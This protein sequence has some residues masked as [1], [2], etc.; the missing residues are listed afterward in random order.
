M[1]VARL[2]ETRPVNRAEQNVVNLVRASGG[3]VQ[4]RH[5]EASGLRRADIQAAARSGLLLRV[6][7]GWYAVPDAPPEVRR[8]ATMGGAATSASVARLHGL[9][10]HDDRTLHVRVPRNASRLVSPDRRD[11]D[12]P[13]RLDPATERVCVHYRSEPAPVSARDPL[14]LALAEMLHCAR[15]LEAITA[16]DSALSSGALTPSGLA[17]VRSL[18]SPGRAKLLD[19]V[20]VGSQSG[21]ETKVRLL[22]RAR[23]IRHREQVEIEGIGWVDLLVGDRLIIEVDGSRHHTGL[24]FEL[25]RRRDFELAMRGY[26]VLRLSYRMVVDD[27]EVTSR[28]LLALIARGEHRWGS[29]ASA[30]PRVGPALPGLRR[31][32]LGARLEAV[33]R[34]GAWADDSR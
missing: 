3:A 31:A 17:T 10:L 2:A 4:L 25:D 1:R 28:G 11:G 16:I 27:W 21:I 33:A 13:A 23:N 12:R 30:S 22:L 15:P 26:L 19:R 20:S 14:P 8:A 29:R 32:D 6:R 18:V 7:R 24:E 5:L 9:W 34:Q